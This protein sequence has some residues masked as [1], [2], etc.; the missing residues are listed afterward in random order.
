MSHTNTNQINWLSKILPKCKL[1]VTSN[2]VLNHPFF[3]ASASDKSIS[4][5]IETSAKDNNIV[6]VENILNSVKLSSSEISNLYR[7]LG[8]VS[9]DFV[10]NQTTFLS[11]QEI[12]KRAK[13]Y[14]EN[15]QTDILDVAVTY[16]GMGHINVLTYS[17]SNNAFFFR[18]DGGANGYDRADHWKY[19]LNLDTG[20]LSDTDLVEAKTVFDVLEKPVNEIPLVNYKFK[21]GVNTELPK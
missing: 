7:L 6:Q 15:G 3:M 10:Y 18:M 13:V 17:L 9:L 12:E 14:H 11:L 21:A 4:E 20:T 2:Q 1:T 19:I 8:D 5:H 16:H